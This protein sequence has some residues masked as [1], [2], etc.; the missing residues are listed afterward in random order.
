MR[1]TDT[2]I[3]RALTVGS[4]VVRYRERMEAHVL[5][6]TLTEQ[7][8]RDEFGT[9]CRSDAWCDFSRADR[10][11][12]YSEDHRPRVGVTIRHR[13]SGEVTTLTYAALFPLITRLVRNHW[14]PRE[15]FE[16][17]LFE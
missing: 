14:T 4:C 16:G 8:I 2:D 15:P 1:P 6:G 11:C 3:D 5:A 9:G 7:V 12:A 13:A 10:W 17:R